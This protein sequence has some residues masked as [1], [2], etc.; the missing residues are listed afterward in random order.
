MF[1]SS[2]VLSPLCLLSCLNIW[3]Q[4]SAVSL[5]VRYHMLVF[6]LPKGLFLAFVFLEIVPSSEMLSLI[7][8]LSLTTHGTLL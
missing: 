2:S 1:S 7:P 6:Y 3:L 5:G 4:H 8:S